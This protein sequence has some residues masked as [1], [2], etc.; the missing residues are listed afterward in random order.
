MTDDRIFH[1]RSGCIIIKEGIK[2]SR[3][4]IDPSTAGTTGP[5]EVNPS[6]LECTKG[7][8][9]LMT[10]VHALAFACGVIA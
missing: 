5:Q 3:L 9:L 1:I 2:A 4:L 8:N 7:P 10:G 6:S